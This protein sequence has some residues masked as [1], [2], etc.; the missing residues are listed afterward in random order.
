MLL[1]LDVGNSQILGGVFDQNQ[2]KL[3][4]RH[5]TKDG[6][7][8]DELGIFLKN[9]LRENNIV[10]D[11]IHEIAIS[12]VV[13]SLDY[14]LRATCLKYFKIDPFILQ[15]GVKTGLKIKTRNPAEI[16]ADLIATAI[17]AIEYFPN[18]HIIIVDFGTATTFTILSKQKEFLGAV[19]TTGIKLSMQ[20]LQ[21]NTA[22]LCGVEIIKPQSILGRS[23]AECIQAGLF[24][25]NT[26]MIKEINTQIIQEAFHNE[27]TVVIGTGGFSHLFRKEKLFTKIMPDLILDG[28]RN[29][30]QMNR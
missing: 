3:R 2:I 11:G 30:I 15:V 6:S 1:C 7:T 26:G 14:S 20:A 4:F 9:V 16:G 21:Q 19:I 27:P 24:Y 17:G 23:T 29:A 13:P 22:K 10:P 25:S 5:K 28:L 12:S 8:S 18:Q